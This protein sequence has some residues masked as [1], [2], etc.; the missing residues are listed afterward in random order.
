MIEDMVESSSVL[1]QAAFVIEGFPHLLR[2]TLLFNVSHNKFI[3]NLQTPRGR[4]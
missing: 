4:L 1:T 2:L 3:T